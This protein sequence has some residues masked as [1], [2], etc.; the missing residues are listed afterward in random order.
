MAYTRDYDSKGD[1]LFIHKKKIK[2]RFS[3]ELGDNYVIDIDGNGNV[4]GVEIFNTSK[5]FKVPKCLLKK[6]TNSTI[7]VKRSG[8]LILIFLY[9]YFEK[10]IAERHNK[11]D[12]IVH[13]VTIPKKIASTA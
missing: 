1:S 8:N 9:F 4:C 7:A 12:K 11:M 10:T 2:T 13:T 3:I 5:L 6:I